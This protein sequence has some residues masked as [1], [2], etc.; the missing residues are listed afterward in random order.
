MR[1]EGLKKPRRTYRLF[2]HTYSQNKPI[3][4]KATIIIVS[5]LLFISNT[6]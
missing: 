1:A 2:S 5:S 3:T 4:T 6:L